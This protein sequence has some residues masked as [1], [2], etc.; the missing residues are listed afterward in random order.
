MPRCTM[1]GCGDGAVRPVPR[2]AVTM[3]TKVAA[4]P[5]HRAAAGREQSA[6]GGERVANGGA[7]DAVATVTLA[8]NE[9]RQAG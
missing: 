5:A 8:Q 2:R 7:L 3:S 4:R 6:R 9:A 1:P